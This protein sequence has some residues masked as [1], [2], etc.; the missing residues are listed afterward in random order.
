LPPGL[1]GG[2]N[3]IWQPD[4]VTHFATVIVVRSAADNYPDYDEGTVRINAFRG[5]VMRDVGQDLIT[6]FRNS[7]SYVRP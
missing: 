5:N 2:R 6:N 7:A 1:A 3:E 4:R